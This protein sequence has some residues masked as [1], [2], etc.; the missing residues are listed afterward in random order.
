MKHK[1]LL[2]KIGRIFYGYMGQ[3][4][5]RPYGLAVL[6]RSVAVIVAATLALLFLST[7]CHAEIL[8]ASYY[9]RA[10]CIEESG[11]YVMANG[12]EFQDE[13]L[14]CATWGLKFGTRIKVKNLRNGR[15]VIVEVADR[16]PAKKLYRRGRVLDLSIRAFSKIANVK[17]GVIH[18]TYEVL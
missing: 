7:M 6:R 11:Q 9:T 12:K 14:T 17:E 8:T 1:L 3:G 16:G 15:S 18:I 5:H 13:A 10:S 2:R 4:D